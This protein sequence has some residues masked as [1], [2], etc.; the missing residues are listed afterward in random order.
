LRQHA[1]PTSTAESASPAGNAH[2][3][4]VED[5]EDIVGR[6]GI[7]S[8]SDV[9]LRPNASMWQGSCPALAIVRP[10]D[11]REL[12]LVMKLCH[13]R[14]QA[15]VPWGGLTGLVN[16]I[17]CTSDDIA[18]S[19]ERMSAIESVDADAGTITVQAG[20]V[21]QQVQEAAV[22][23]GWL[24]AVDLGARGSA[25]IGG[26][27]STNAGGNSVVRYGMMREQVLGLEAVL[28]DGTV[29]SAM[30]EMIKNNAGYDL[31]HL[32]IGSEGTLGIV[33][34]AVLRLR[35]AP[36]CTQTALVALDSFDKV[37]Q[38]LRRLGVAFEGKLSAFEIMWRSHYRLLVDVARKHPAFLPTHYPYYVLIESTGAD[39]EREKQQF[40]DTLQ[41]LMES[42]VVAA[43]VIAQSG[44]QS[45]QL[46]RLRDDVETL[47]AH[48]SPSVVF[49]ISLPI[50][51]M[52]RYVDR[53]EREI[54]ERYPTARFIALGHVGDGNIHLGVGPTDDA[55]GVKT[56]VYE[57][58]RDIGGSISAE[59]GIGLDKKEFLSCS[60]NPAEIAL[61]R[62]LKAALD[63]KNIL[64]PGKVL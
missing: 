59:H 22:E 64:N 25:T 29:I 6:A 4:I 44:P 7:I 43:A 11:T 26:M 32:F 40:T 41:A 3:F 63:P 51:E 62:Q 53:V 28:A 14:G 54:N 9:A 31:K 15:V 46:W 21:L 8:G 42:E 52:E 57:R 20:A 50:R 16:G 37:S 58:L 18:I 19:L 49:D 38:L 2:M 34:R 48:M 45:D 13:E 33:T 35:P 27:I 55:H 12:S 10:E 56:I 23:A 24:F 17:T 60:R 5:I 61:M 30:N 47:V 39:A 36:L 1:I